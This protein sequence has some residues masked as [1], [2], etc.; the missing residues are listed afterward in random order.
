[1][2]GGSEHSQNMFQSAH[3][4]SLKSKMKSFKNITIPPRMIIARRVTS[5][6]SEPSMHMHSHLNHQQ[7]HHHLHN[8]NNAHHHPRVI[9]GDDL[10]EKFLPNAAAEDD[11]N[12][13]ASDEFRMYEFKVRKCTRSRSHDWTECPFA[14]PGEKARRRCPRRFIYSGDLCP[15]FREGYCFRGD[16][17][18]FAHGVFEHWLHPSRYRTQACK[19]GTTCQ[20]KICFFAHTPAQLRSHLNN[21][22][23][24]G[25]SCGRHR[26]IPH[27]VTPSPTSILD[28]R[29]MM[30]PPFSPVQSGGGFSPV[31][32]VS[33]RL[34]RTEPAGNGGYNELV[35]NMQAMNLNA[36]E[37]AP[38]VN[39][40]LIDSFAACNDQQQLMF[41]PSTSSSASASGSGLV[42]PKDGSYTATYNEDMFGNDGAM[43][44][45]DFEWVND[46]L[47]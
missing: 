10:F 15:D 22:G 1:M 20:R 38:N 42:R 9:T 29:N 16:H 8:N 31:S 4:L 35:H 7:H 17:C 26:G 3:Q 46:L 2:D 19:D 25:G 41:S 40:A 18:E 43:A 37:Q 11:S 32:C 14:H 45:L 5:L 12:P 30:S 39:P 23:G 36:G 21:T 47:I 13:Y 44:R 27:P 33:S 34:S 24:I 28:T 6:S